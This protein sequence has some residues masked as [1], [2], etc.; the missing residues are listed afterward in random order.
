MVAPNK[1]W[2][3]DGQPKNGQHYPQANPHPL[4]VNDS[5]DCH[6][7][8]LPKE[9]MMSKSSGGGKIVVYAAVVGIFAALVGAAYVWKP[10][11]LVSPKGR[12]SCALQVD[13]NRGGDVYT[14]MYRNDTGEEPWLRMVNTLG[15]K[16]GEEKY[17]P[18]RRCAEIAQRMEQL[19]PDGLT[20]LDFRD[21]PNTPKQQVIC[22][23]TRRSGDACHLVVTLQVGAD[24]YEELR[25]VAG[26]L[27]PGN[28]PSYQGSNPQPQPQLT[29]ISLEPYL[30][31]ED[32]EAG[33]K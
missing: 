2:S 13:A 33:K 25:K 14:V 20:Q 23:R 29:S 11:F 12:F 27:L 5:P 28:E 30:A 9:A 24:P 7:C 16:P 17:T 10:E 22:A 15:N 4:Y 19:R 31:K 26:A 1:K 3:C 32:R 8:G 6:I 18:E 21:D